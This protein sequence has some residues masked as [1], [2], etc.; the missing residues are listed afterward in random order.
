MPRSSV[1]RNGPCGIQR[2]FVSISRGSAT[3][4][5]AP[6]LALQA[7]RAFRNEV[8]NPL[9]LENGCLTPVREDFG[10]EPLL[11]LVWHVCDRRAVSERAG[12]TLEL[13]ARDDRRVKE[14]RD[15]GIPEIGR[16]ESL[17]STEP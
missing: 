15:S 6:E 4:W 5:N 14:P 11:G 3:R 12:A 13:P 17:A 7:P 9:W 1:A 2:E 10:E 8:A 16:V